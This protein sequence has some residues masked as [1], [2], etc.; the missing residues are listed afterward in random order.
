MPAVWPLVGRQ[1]V[2]RRIAEAMC[3][4]GCAGVVLVGAAGVGKTRLAVEALHEAGR[5][6]L[7]TLWTVATEAAASIPY[8]PVVDLLPQPE[9][10]PP[11]GGPSPPRTCSSE[12]SGVWASGAVGGGSSWVS[13]T[14]TCSTTRRPRWCT[15]SREPARHRSLPRCEAVSTARTR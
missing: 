5:R 6:G 4:P 12:P 15:A 3:R 13:T 11:D 1:D 7:D 10:E 2:L 9:Q 14:R 8:G